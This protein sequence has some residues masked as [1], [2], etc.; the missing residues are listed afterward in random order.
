MFVNLNI[1]VP[2]PGKEYIAFLFIQYF[3]RKY[4]DMLDLIPSLRSWLPTVAG[5]PFAVATIVAATGSV[6][7]PV[8]T[9]MLVAGSGSILGSLSGGCVEGAVV[10]LAIEALDD[11]GGVEQVEVIADDLA[12]RCWPDPKDRH[13][14][15]V[16][17]RLLADLLVEYLL[18]EWPA[19]SLDAGV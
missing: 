2:D 16:G 1:P 3:T 15:A 10:A 8:G 9:S 13:F 19:S 14:S 7:R 6:P 12:T 17:H 11:A 5:G 4:A 18:R